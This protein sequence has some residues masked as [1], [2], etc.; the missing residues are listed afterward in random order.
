M[1][2][3]ERV[4]E[5]FLKYVQI[6]SESYNEAEF[7]KVLFNQLKSIGLDVYI[8][9]AGEI[10]GSN[11]GN[12]I[13]KLSGNVA[14]EPMLFSCH[15]DTVKPGMDIKPIVKDRIVYS[16]GTTI[17]GGDDKGGIAAII[18]ALTMIKEYNLPHPTIEIAFTIAEEVGLYGSKNID[19]TKLTSKKAFIFDTSGEPGTIINKGPA[20]D[21][22]IV[23]ITGKPAHAGVAPENGISAIQIA[24]EAIN[25][26]KLLR[27]D[28][29]TT[30]NIGKISGGTAINIVCP[31]V[32]VEAEARSTI[33]AKL[34]I[35]TN[36]MI[37]EFKKSVAKF[38]GVID[39][40][41]TRLYGPFVVDEDTEVV[42][43]A[44]RALKNIGIDSVVKSS[45]GGSDT[46]I[47]NCN[48]IKAIN[49]SSGE[50][51][52]HTLQESMKIDDLNTLVKLILELIKEGISK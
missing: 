31:E 20:Q 8:D 27:I 15:M 6:S 34:D 21:K 13:A 24:A 42:K 3:E 37:D 30:A 12:I 1:I 33:E 43:Q 41:V 48:G 4:L 7:A 51:N 2:N 36:H 50:R 16:D 45:G 46:N 39:I 28:E 26:M 17:L 9:N 11:T 10:V 14:G 52:P 35:Q 23:K 5:R 25:N 22:I 40:N 44:K 47:F 38:G 49:L 32:I 18:E 29:D 19:Y